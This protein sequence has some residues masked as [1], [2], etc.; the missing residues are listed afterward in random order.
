MDTVLSEK[1]ILCR[2][3]EA[4][5]ECENI[6]KQDAFADRCSWCAPAYVVL[7][8]SSFEATAGESVRLCTLEERTNAT[9]RPFHAR[10]ASTILAVGSIGW[11]VYASIDG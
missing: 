8:Y 1:C 7:P 6:R 10:F 2:K 11:H 4:A 5:S 9:L 3:V